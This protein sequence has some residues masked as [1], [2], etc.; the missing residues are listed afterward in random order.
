MDVVEKSFPIVCYMD[1]GKVDNRARFAYV[2]FEN[3]VEIDYNQFRIWNECTVYISE[4][5]CICFSVKWISNQDTCF[6]RH[7]ICTKSPSFL[8]S[9]R[10]I[11]FC[12]NSIVDIQLF[13]GK[14]LE[15]G[16]SVYFTFVRGH[17][18]IYG[19][20]RADWLAKNATKKNIQSAAKLFEHLR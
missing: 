5:L 10:N 18:G 14:L 2:I 12:N 17:V 13:L 1:G 11:L 15:R 9:L 19:N 8:E 4:F 20:E 3:G 7:F 16:I 6:S